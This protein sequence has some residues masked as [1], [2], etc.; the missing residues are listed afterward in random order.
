M[1]RNRQITC[2]SIK[3]GFAAFT[4]YSKNS[5]QVAELC[6]IHYLAKNNTIPTHILPISSQLKNPQNHPSSKVYSTKQTYNSHDNPA[7]HRAE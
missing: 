3:L 1:K 5:I 6:V 2:P 7:S 4:K